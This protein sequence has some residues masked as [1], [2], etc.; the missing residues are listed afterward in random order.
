[1]AAIPR[2][3]EEVLGNSLQRDLMAFR[4]YSPLAATKGSTRKA[5]LITDLLS[6]CDGVAAGQ[7]MCSE[8][9]AAWSMHELRLFIARLRGL[10]FMVTVGPR[11]R[12][13][14]LVAA[15]ISAEGHPRVRGSH[16][17]GRSAEPRHSPGPSEDTGKGVCPSTSASYSP[18][19]PSS[20]VSPGPSE[21]TG[22]GVCPSTSASYSPG[23]PSSSVALVAVDSAAAPVKLQFK[24]RRR[25]AK[26]WA[27]L[28]RK[29]DR[30]RNLK[31]VEGE[32][33]N[34]LQDHGEM[35]S[36]GDLR[37]MVGK[38][39]GLALDDGEYRRRFD[40]T[41]SQLTSPPQ[42]KRRARQ[43][44]TIAGSSR[45]TRTRAS[46]SSRAESG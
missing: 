7:R 36:I 6:A 40:R 41:L 42:Q 9:M 23:L 3:W 12:R 24:L 33:R 18:G 27:R 32:L 1:M 5:D 8:L 26:R 28:L 2:V 30:K 43:R 37:S 45:R 34:A 39:L 25:W 17:P 15:I 21:D 4:R 19:L 10:G 29:R 38:A 14:D 22:K 16:A 44:F 46:T 13:Q 20:S 31:R 35:T 11:P